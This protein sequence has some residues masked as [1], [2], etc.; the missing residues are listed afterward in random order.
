MPPLHHLLYL[1]NRRK[2][3]RVAGTHPGRRKRHS[4][5]ANPR[6]RPANPPLFSF[7]TNTLLSRS[8]LERRPVAAAGADFAPK[9]RWTSAGV[10]S[11]SLVVYPVC[12]LSRPPPRRLPPQPSATRIFTW[13][14]SSQLK[15]SGREVVWRQSCCA[16]MCRPKPFLLPL[17]H[18]SCVKNK[19]NKP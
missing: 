17:L 16:I 7:Y 6:A 5:A 13:H 18:V 10:P 1:L 11:S 4:T 15:L 9:R 3:Y 19:T 12:S 8:P 14:L 2:R